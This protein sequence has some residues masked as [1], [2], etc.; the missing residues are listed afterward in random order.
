MEAIA[1]EKAL[2][3]LRKEKR[4]F[5]Q[6]LDLIIN[7]QK[8]D[9]RKESINLFVPIH[10]VSPRRICAILTRKVDYVDCITKDDFSKFKELKDIKKLA[11]RYDFFIAAAP[12]MAE[13]ATK[14]GRVFGPMGKMPSPQ[15][16]IVPMD[17]D[18]SVKAMIEKMKSIV[19]IKSKER[20]L[21]IAVGKED[22]PDKDL[23]EN[24]ETILTAVT[25]A[26]P[27]KGNNIKNV[28]I[29]FTMSKPIQIK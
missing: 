15:A 7:L 19:K 26:L 2:E 11:K 13:I 1:I 28:L 20:S 14:F 27:Q 5:N 4:K 21:K 6:S 25:N 29:K 18:V 10:H 22:M 12:L 8:F 9:A 3:E 23:K 16:G 17:N 24:I